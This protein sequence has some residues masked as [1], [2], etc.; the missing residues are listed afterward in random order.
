MLEFE[1]VSLAVAR[2]TLNQL[3]SGLEHLHD[4]TNYWKKLRRAPT[5]DDQ[6][7]N[8]SGLVW[9]A[10]LPQLLRPHETAIRYPHVVNNLAKAWSDDDARAVLFDDLLN[11]P[12]RKR[13]GFPVDVARELR[14]LHMAVEEA[15]RRREASLR[16]KTAASGAVRA[17]V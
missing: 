3:P 14:A 2:A 13:K 12:R 11:S 6:R 16:N 8:D 17:E 9:M 7:V 15:L 1:P 4:Q 5:A 10:R